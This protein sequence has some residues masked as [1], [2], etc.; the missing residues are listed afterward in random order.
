MADIFISYSSNDAVKVRRLVE[1]LNDKGA[2][3]WSDEEQINH[4]DDTI[5]KMSDGIAQCRYYLI[6][7]SPFFEKKT[8]M[9][10]VRKEFKMPILKEN[11][12]GNPCIIPVRTKKG[13][14]IPIEIA[15]RAYADV[16]T[17]KRWAKNF[18]RLCKAPRIDH[19]L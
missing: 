11:K 18:P 2:N 3:L 19:V 10:W 8:P 4:G 13:G 12:E 5:K 6:F 7:L 1:A 16:T 9:S 15:E 14:S 17:V